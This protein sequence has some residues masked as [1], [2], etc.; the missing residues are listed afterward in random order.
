MK[1]TL[2]KLYHVVAVRALLPLAALCSVHQQLHVR[3]IGTKAVMTPVLALHTGCLFAEHADPNIA[4]DVL[5]LNEPRAVAVSAV[6]G[7]GGCQLF[8]L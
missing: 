2:C 4:P 6:G 1:A 3:I 8:D 7:I 5:W